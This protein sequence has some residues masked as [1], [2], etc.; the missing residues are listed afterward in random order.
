[1]LREGLIMRSVRTRVSAVV[2]ALASVAGGLAVT[3]G[4]QVGASVLTYKCVGATNDKAA[5]VNGFTA[6]NYSTAGFL[7]YVQSLVGPFGGVVTTQPEL[8]ASIGTTDTPDGQNATVGSTVTRNFA[9]SVGLPDNLIS[10]AKTYLGI[11]Q[12]YLRNSNISVTG[13]GVS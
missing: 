2:V 7:N 5:T 13:T 9:A 1:M 11:S 4:T 10:D 6:V 3:Q 12:V 8:A